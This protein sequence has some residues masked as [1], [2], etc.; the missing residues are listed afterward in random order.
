MALIKLFTF[1]IILQLFYS[2]GITILTYALMPFGLQTLTVTLQPFQNQT[3]DQ[4]SIATRIQSSTQNQINIPLVDLAFLVVYTGNI[5]IDLVL[6]FFTALPGMFNLLV[7]GLCLLFN[8]NAYYTVSI[9]LF[10][11]AFLTITYFISIMAFLLS[12]RSRGSVV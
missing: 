1:L 8:V 9:K 12:L 2:F 10:I 3:E 11:F 6:N 7:D 5:F 4:S